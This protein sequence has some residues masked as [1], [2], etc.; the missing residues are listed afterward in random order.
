MA[1]LVP[2]LILLFCCVGGFLLNSFAILPT[3]SLIEFVINFDKISFLGVCFMFMYLFVYV[4][5]KVMI[6][7]SDLFCLHM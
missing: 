5:V 6:W 4:I 7:G 2:K 3:E 1:F